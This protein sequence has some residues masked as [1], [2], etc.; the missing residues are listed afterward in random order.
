VKCHLKLHIDIT[1]HYITFILQTRCHDTRPNYR[2]E[3]E[4]DWEVA[5]AEIT[6]PSPLPIVTRDTH[7]FT[8]RSTDTDETHTNTLRWG[9]YDTAGK[10][11]MEMYSLISAHPTGVA[12]RY[13]IKRVKLITTGS[14]NVKF[15]DVLTHMLGFS[16]GTSYQPRNLGHTAPRTIDCHLSSFPRFTSTATF[17]NDRM[18]YTRS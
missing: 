13:Q 18:P 8:L 7:F 11:V 5:L 12:F 17:W 4:G 1:L 3:L 16:A 15:S 14:Y 9:Y 6:V 2:M 10:V